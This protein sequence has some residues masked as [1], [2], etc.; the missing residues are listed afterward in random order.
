MFKNFIVYFLL[1]VFYVFADQKESAS[2]EQDTKAAVMRLLKAELSQKVQIP[3]FDITLDHWAPNWENASSQG[4]S[5]DSL[6][7][8]KNRFSAMVS[9]FKTPK[10]MSGRIIYHTKVPV[11][12][13][14]IGPD[15]EILEDDI[16]YVEIDTDDIATQY[17]SHKE[18]LIGKTSRQ[19]VLKV[20]VPIGK[21]QIK[22]PVVIKKGT[23]VRVIY[24]HDTIRITNKGIAMKD[25][26]K[27]ETIPV[28][29]HNQD[30]RHAKKVIYAQV[31]NAQ[32]A[33]VSM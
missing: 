2:Q 23:I 25:A 19:G 27:L 14:P 22:A 15:E 24:E 31:L 29:I 28:E 1:S 17:I 21:H 8:T 30:S 33:R 20:G 10:R 5:V 26:T 13:R 9:G 11:L 7:V 4:L 6:T 18:E 12:S 16:T 32:D 3:D